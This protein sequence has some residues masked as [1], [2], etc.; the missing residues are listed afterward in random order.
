MV[1]APGYFG[2]LTYMLVSGSGAK[3]AEAKR[4]VPQATTALTFDFMRELRQP[5]LYY[6]LLN[7]SVLQARVKALQ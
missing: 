6:L 5:G 4:Q 1:L 2:E 7:G 3:I